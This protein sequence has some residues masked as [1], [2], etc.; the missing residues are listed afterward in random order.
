M[1]QA[2]SACAGV[3]PSE[4][5]IEIVVLECKREWNELTSGGDELGGQTAIRVAK[6]SARIHKLNVFRH[7]WA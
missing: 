3:E 4:K 7:G 5:S 2:D 6:L 1:R